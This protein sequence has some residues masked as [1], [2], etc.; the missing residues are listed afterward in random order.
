MPRLPLL[1][2]A[3]QA[4]NVVANA[5]KCVNLFPE[6]NP[7]SSQAPVPVTHYQTPGIRLLATPSYPAVGRCIYRATD[8]QGF[9]VIGNKVFYVDPNW[10]LTEL[11]TIG[12]AATPVSMADNSIDIVLVDGSINGYVI[13]LSSH[14]FSQISDP[15]FYG[16]DRVDYLDTFF[17]FNRPGTNQVYSS[18]SNSVS[19]D[20]LDIAGKTGGADFVSTLIVKH[21]EAWI[22]G[23]FTSEVWGLVGGADFPFAPLQGA[24]MDHGCVARY[25]IAKADV[26]IFWLSQDS[27][28]HRMVMRSKGYKA[29]VIST[30]AL[31]VEIQSYQ[32]VD[33]AIGYTYQQGGHT[34]YV[35]TFPQA[36]K[37]W[38][39]DLSTEQWHQWAYIDNNGTLHRHRGNVGTFL[40]GQN[41][42]V[43]YQNGKLYALD[44][45]KFTDNGQPIVR[46]RSFPHI[47]NDGNRLTISRVLAD[48]G[49]G[50]IEGLAVD[51]VQVSDFNWDFNN[52]FGA[53]PT[54]L[55]APRIFLRWSI[56][57]G[58]SYGTAVAQRM[59]S[60][61]QYDKWPSWAPIGMG[62]DFV[63]ELSWS[64][65]GPAAL[66]GVFY[67]PKEHAS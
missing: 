39:F 67:V 44:P 59:G 22:L 13:N 28:G 45:N 41:A 62:R 51:D 27:Q 26:A 12:N 8:G 46:I 21:R 60:T 64:I 17:L 66:N 54:T 25:S 9:A 43:D 29:E 36:D 3:Y 20:A 11:G 48:V 35:L 57:R 7:Q 19:F 47:L 55:L 53:T 1:G 14:A 34:F 40:Y 58:K 50:D 10:A 16:A 15:A 38:V 52:D 65:N 37:T 61:G 56:N 2:G 24:F 6:L 33:D 5:Q 23:L 49:V 32:R 30:R 63:F 42:V 4:R 31:D 18:L